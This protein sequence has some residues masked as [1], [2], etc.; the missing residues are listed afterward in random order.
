MKVS[1]TNHKGNVNV[2]C[3]CTK[4]CSKEEDDVGRMPMTAGA[5]NVPKRQ[6]KTKLEVIT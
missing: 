5:A 2:S 4:C 3:V 6:Q 1:S